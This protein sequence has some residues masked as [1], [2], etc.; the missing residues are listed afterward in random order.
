MFIQCKTRRMH[1]AQRIIIYVD[2]QLFIA[3][4]SRPYQQLLPSKQLE[5]GEKEGY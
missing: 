4:D 1:T 2:Y 3:T 5:P